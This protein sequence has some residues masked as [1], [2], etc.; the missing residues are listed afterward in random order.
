M[1]TI[2]YLL[3]GERDNLSR[4]ESAIQIAQQKS[5]NENENFMNALFTELGMMEGINSFLVRSDSEIDWNTTYSVVKGMVVI[6]TEDGLLHPVMLVKENT[7]Y[8]DNANLNQII[9]FLNNSIRVDQTRYYDRANCWTTGSEG[10]F[11]EKYHVNCDK[12]CTAGVDDYFMNEQDVINVFKNKLSIPDSIC[13]IVGITE[14]CE[15]E[16]IECDIKEV[17]KRYTFNIDRGDCGIDLEQMLAD[18][19]PADSE[20]AIDNLFRQI[21]NEVTPCISI[22]KGCRIGGKLSYSGKT[23]LFAYKIEKEL[24]GKYII[25][26]GCKE[27]KDSYFVG[28][29]YK[30][31]PEASVTG[32]MDVE[33]TLFAYIETENTE[34]L[35]IAAETGHKDAQFM[36]YKKLDLDDES[37]S[38]PWLIKAAENGHAE[39]Q[40]ELY[41]KYHNIDEEIRTPSD[42]ENEMLWLKRSADA[43]YKDA[44][45]RIIDEE[46]DDEEMYEY[47]L[48]A[49]DAGV[50][51]VY[52]KLGR[53]AYDKQEHAEAARWWSK[54]V[55][56]NKD[57]YG[58]ILFDGLGVE[59][60]Y[61][62]ALECYKNNASDIFD[63]MR[64]MGIE[65][66]PDKAKTIVWEIIA[67]RKKKEMIKAANV[68]IDREDYEKCIELYDK[69]GGIEALNGASDFNNYAWSYC[70][71][72]QYDKAVDPALKAVEL[73]SNGANLDTLATAY[74][75]LGRYDEALKYYEQSRDAYLADEDEYS[76][77]SESKKIKALQQKKHK[78]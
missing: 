49:A 69:A 53:L 16:E 75:G 12:V 77:E 27:V 24:L 34:Y 61:V 22:S 45:E 60:D 48:K 47:L 70:M 46:L 74:E 39:A 30:D 78:K 40:Y 73:D 23:L 71:T 6:T 51:R 8:S 68:A 50:D 32:G 31:Q 21:Y 2:E 17:E 62:K 28:Q 76:A 63:L 55:W 3:I 26:F 25:G 9:K 42:D 7:N 5:E 44:L 1:A 13:S 36:Y 58:E 67:E 37:A 14:W 56:R 20:A 33:D 38:L 66:S 41:R 4:L 59:H 64:K 35:R 65:P 15:H 19:R 18:A 43:G 29:D 57:K 72:G 11:P 54:G 52:D 10:H